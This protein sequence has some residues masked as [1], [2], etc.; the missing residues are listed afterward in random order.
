MVELTI[1][2]GRNRQVRRMF[3]AVEHR[4]LRLVRTELGPLK[5]GRLKPGSLRKLGPQEVGELYRA[6]GL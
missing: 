5:L 4:V 3:E 6:V 1:H 2:E